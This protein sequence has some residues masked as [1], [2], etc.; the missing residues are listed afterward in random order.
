MCDPGWTRNPS[1]PSSKSVDDK[2][3]IITKVYGGDPLDYEA[4]LEE[5][6]AHTNYF[7][8]FVCDTVS[9]LHE[10]KGSGKT[11]LFEGA[12]GMLLDIDFGTYPYVT[13]SHPNTGG[14]CAGAGV[15]PQVITVIGVVK[16]T[17]RVG[18]DRS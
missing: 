16:A 4:V 18:E 9:M 14:V 7:R 15:G 3:E 6:R 11:L 5:C 17:T 13:S 10:Y 1:R 12:Q 8:P 2:N